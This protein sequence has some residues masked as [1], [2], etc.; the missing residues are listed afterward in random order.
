MRLRVWIRLVKSCCALNTLLAG[1]PASANPP[2]LPEVAHSTIEYPSVEAALKALR[3]K[4]GVQIRDQ[5]GWTLITDTEDGNPVLW[6]FAPKS[7]PWAYPSVVKRSIVNTGQGASID[8]QVHCEAEKA[9]CDNLVRQ[10]QALNEQLAQ[11]VTG[12]GPRPAEQARSPTADA[13]NVTSDSAPGGLPS[14]ESVPRAQRDPC[15]LGRARRRS[16]PK[17]LRS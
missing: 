1:V 13:I 9:P 7:D 10:F 16:I 12:K 8:M 3:T 14:S 2:P 11:A 17:G 15:L 5:S 6:S 4:P